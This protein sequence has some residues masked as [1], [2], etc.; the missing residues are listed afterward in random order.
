MANRS[1]GGDLVNDSGKRRSE[2]GET[3]TLGGVR[4][5][6]IYVQRGPYMSSEPLKEAREIATVTF[7]GVVPL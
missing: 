2:I 3:R 6:V 1:K 5:R 7:V 4:Y